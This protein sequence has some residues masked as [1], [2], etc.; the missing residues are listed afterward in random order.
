MWSLVETTDGYYK[1][2]NRNSQMAIGISGSSV[3]EGGLC[4]QLPDAGNDNQK[5]RIQVVQ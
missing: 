2:I 5:W 4:V 3:L 1:I